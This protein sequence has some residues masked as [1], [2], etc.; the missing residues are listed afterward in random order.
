MLLI[1][2]EKKT[3]DVKKKRKEKYL[4]RLNPPSLAHLR[5]EGGLVFLFFVSFLVFL[6]VCLFVL[7]VYISCAF[8]K[9]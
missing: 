7:S 1:Q 6:F 4:L 9:E 5:I 3:V 8:I 2:S